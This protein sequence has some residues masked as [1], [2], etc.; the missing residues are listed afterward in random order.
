MVKKRMIGVIGS[1]DGD[2]GLE[3]LA[4]E[5]GRTIAIAGYVL[6]NGGLGGVME[7]SARGC[8]KGGGVTVGI[9]PGLKPS[10][11]NQYIDIPF[12]TGLGEMRNALI[13]RVSCALIAI[14]GGYGTLSEVAL[15]LKASKPVVGLK[16]WAISDDIIP[17]TSPSDAVKKALDA[18][19]KMDTL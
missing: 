4:E 1:G 10:D 17:A 5:V 12:A 2:P 19:L 18:A 9:L 11:A 8:K 6:V 15:G 7:A 13:V 3:D 16:T 14:G